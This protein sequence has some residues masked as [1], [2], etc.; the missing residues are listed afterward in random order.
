MCEFT[1]RLPVIQC[2]T[3]D[4]LK[5]FL[6]SVCHYEN[7][8]IIR[9]LDIDKE[10]LVECQPTELKMYFLCTQGIKCA[11]YTSTYIYITYKKAYITMLKK[12]VKQFKQKP[13]SDE[14]QL[15]LCKTFGKEYLEAYRNEREMKKR[16][17]QKKHDEEINRFI[18]ETEERISELEISIK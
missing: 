1:N 5:T 11:V 13:I 2:I 18:C 14:W 6:E 7:V 3:P 17:I 8:Q 16:E 15:Y 4:I 10:K 12:F 9:E